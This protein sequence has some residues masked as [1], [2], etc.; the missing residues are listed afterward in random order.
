MTPRTLWKRVFAERRAVLLPLLVAFVANIGVLGLG[1]VPLRQGVKGAEQSAID[2]RLRLGL[3]R[4]AD[5]DAKASRTG[6][7]RADLEMKKFYA[8][9][10]PRSYQEAASLTQFWLKRIAGESQLNF[11]SGT[12]A[13]KALQEPS[14]VVKF[15]A[16]VDLAGD[17]ANIRRFLYE[18]ETAP[19]FV[20]IES[21]QLSQ[22]G[23]L[24]QGGQLAI[25]LEVSTYYVD[26]KADRPRGAQ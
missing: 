13:H 8:E 17:Y 7:E 4:K 11:E 26:E 3:A 23:T 10:L 22:A 19:Q 6:K 14:T 21:V 18:V 25:S 2:A 12:Y 24:Q 15:T 9:V 16:R 5:L 1:V 20:I